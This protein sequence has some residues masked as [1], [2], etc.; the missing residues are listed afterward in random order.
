MDRYK[1]PGYWR[2]FLTN[3]VTLNPYGILTSERMTRFAKLL[4]SFRPD[5]IISYVSAMEAFAHFLDERGGADFRP[6][7]IWLSAE[8]TH[9]FQKELIERVFRSAVYDMYGSV[10]VDH[11]AAECDRREGLHINAD[12]RT[13]E[14]VGET[15]QPLH[16]GE[17][18]ELVVTDLINYAAPLI[19]YRTGDLG[20]LLGHTCSCGRAL[21]LMGGVVG[22]VYD[23]FVLPDG[24]QLFGGAFST[25]FYN[26]VSEVRSFQVHQT[27]RDAAIVRIVPTLTCDREK[28]SAEV[29]RAFRSF[30]LGKVHFEIRFVER[31]DQEASGKFR[32]VKSDVSNPHRI[33]D[34]TTDSS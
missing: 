15:G 7:A 1:T 11:C 30:T 27:H 33:I 13:V 18:G 16:P 2:R 22:R 19:R 10:E 3:S 14:I 34:H 31:I 20:S 17:T 8:R 29:L 25:F 12:S 24:S 28:L 9:P 6:K 4:E 26:Y 5:L 32:Y 21:P 23:M